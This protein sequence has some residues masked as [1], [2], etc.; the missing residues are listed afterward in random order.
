MDQVILV[1]KKDKGI[2]FQKK[3]KAH[4]LGQ[5]HRAF[6]IFI[7]NSAGQLMIQRRAK[8]KYHCGGLWSNTCCSHPRPNEKIKQAAHR[9]LQEE[10]GFDCSLKK[11]FEFIYKVKFDNGLWENEYVHVFFGKSDK[12]PRV[13]SYEV[14]TWKYIKLNNLKQEIK[15]YP[16]DFT[17]W[18]KKEI[19][20]SKFN[21]SY[22][23]NIEKREQSL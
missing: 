2:G 3:L 9:R 12:S 14:S 22:N 16:E 7:F 6:S 19:Y 4:Q 13:N 18:I 17:Y 8:E 15:K 11:V 23:K 20:N 1:N 5:L 21:Q 10:M